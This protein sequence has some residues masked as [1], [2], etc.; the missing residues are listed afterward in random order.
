MKD[1]FIMQ[2][3]KAAGKDTVAMYLR[4]L[5]GTPSWM[6]KYWIGRLLSWIPFRSKMKITR[7]AQA[8]KE[9]LAVMLRVPVERFEDRDF[10]EHYFVDF[11]N[12]KF[13]DD[14]V[15]TVPKKITDKSFVRHL[16]YDD[17]EVAKKYNLSIRQVLQFWGTNICRKFL[18]DKLWI[19]MTF[20]QEPHNLIIAD[21]RFI[22]ENEVTSK[23]KNT[24]IIHITRPD[25]PIGQHPSEKELEVLLAKKK[26]D[27]LIENDGTLEDLFNKV[28]E[29]YYFNLI[30]T[31][32]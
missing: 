24:V 6:H 7:Y 32:Q 23:M 31:V 12:Y 27:Y 8:L 4:Y 19:N 3:N 26:Y 16:S 9:V 10:K 1:V 2:G 20:G 13:Y 5:I 22:I 25:M 28:K 30:W 18:G 29:L 21:Q 14:R 17:L 11:N 15:T